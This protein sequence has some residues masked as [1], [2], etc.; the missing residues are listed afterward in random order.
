[1][2]RALLLESSFALE[3]VLEFLQRWAD[4]HAYA[5]SPLLGR[6]KCCVFGV[7]YA[8]Y[9]VMCCVYGVVSKCI[10]RALLIE[11]GAL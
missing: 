2:Y 9:G 11:C 5:L 3:F 6:I 1:V 4:S 7:M 8:V 10:S